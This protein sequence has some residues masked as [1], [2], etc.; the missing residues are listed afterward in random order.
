MPI[1]PLSVT[2][3][4]F[5]PTNAGADAAYRSYVDTTEN[6]TGMHL[7]NQSADG[8]KD[9]LFK[10]TSGYGQ[11]RMLI[12]D[13][14]VNGGKWLRVEDGKTYAVI[15]KY[16]GGNGLSADSTYGLG[17]G[18]T[19]TA[20]DANVGTA[21]TTSMLGDV[22]SYDSK[23]VFGDNGNWQYVAAVINA[24][25]VSRTTYDKTAEAW[26]TASNNGRYIVLSPESSVNASIF[27]ESVTVYE[28]MNSSDEKL[29]VTQNA[30]GSFTVDTAES[31]TALN[32][33]DELNA[34]GEKAFGYAAV[35]GEDTEYITA[36][37]D[38]CV[39][40]DSTPTYPT[41]TMDSSFDVWNPNNC[42]AWSVV[43]SGDEAHGKVLQFSVT[44][45]GSIGYDVSIRKQTVEVGKTY[46]VSMDAKILD[47]DIGTFT[48][49]T[50]VSDQSGIGVS[51]G[52]AW[53]STQGTVSTNDLNNKTTEWQRIGFI[54]TPNSSLSY[55]YLPIG[56]GTA[57]GTGNVP[58]T[59]YIDNVN[60][61]AIDIV[62]ENAKAGKRAVTLGSIRK[63]GSDN[64]NYVSA[65][66]RFN[67]TLDDSVIAD[68]D[69]IGF[70]VLPTNMANAFNGN[71][72]EAENWAASKAKYASCK[73]TIYSKADTT[74]SYQLILTGLSTEDG[75]TAY[76]TN[77]TAKMYVKS[78]D[79]NYTYYDLSTTSYA[80]VKAA[81][82]VYGTVSDSEWA[83]F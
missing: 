76:K 66:L 7:G 33:V 12:R 46:Y 41:A 3:P 16:K 50:T 31:G 15:V 57:V 8:T 13:D 82:R 43:D 40:C 38:N 17:I 54:Y 80:E 68:A 21:P 52:K 19:N 26:K 83:T 49:R 4:F 56:F 30:D 79:G 36:V 62:D 11:R 29:I 61:T 58:Y 64:G 67:G 71:W 37:A 23:I 45:A 42:K 34:Y 70:A 77:F 51:G 18:L 5:P 10:T 44:T 55:D 20:T 63:A 32:K 22:L 75:K 27:I 60:I 69:D 9:I 81:Y 14:D 48:L 53:A 65:G 6:A 73:D 78:A 35:K 24:D 1:P 72:F 47:T 2:I 25:G 39:L 28:K 59:L 74:T